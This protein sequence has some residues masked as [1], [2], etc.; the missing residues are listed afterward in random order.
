[1]KAFN[2]DNEIL[3]RLVLHILAAVQ[4]FIWKSPSVGQIF[5][6]LILGFIRKTANVG[7]IMLCIRKFSL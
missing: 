3:D 6:G 7:Q 5:N 4:A 1:M 2:F